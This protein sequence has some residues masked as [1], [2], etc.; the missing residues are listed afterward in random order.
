MCDAPSASIHGCFE[1]P[2]GLAPTSVD[3]V[4]RFVGIDTNVIYRARLRS[5]HL[6]GISTP[7]PRQGRRNSRRFNGD[8]LLKH[9]AG[10]YVHLE[11]AG[12]TM[13]PQFGAR[14]GIR[15]PCP[16]RRHAVHAT[17]G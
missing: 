5:L 10:V 2:W 15:A 12:M 6:S 14:L 16:A 8:E 7:S 11:G 3:L 4:P 9:S 13:T 17:R 1:R